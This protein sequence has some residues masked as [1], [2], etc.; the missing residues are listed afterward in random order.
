[1]LGSLMGHLVSARRRLQSDETGTAGAS[2]RLRRPIR[3]VAAAAAAT[4]AAR[5]AVVS[6]RASQPAAVVE[7]PKERRRDAGKANHEPE[8]DRA[9]HDKEMHLLQ[10]RLEGHYTDMKNFIRTRAEPTIFYLPAK[11]TSKTQRCLEETRSAIEQKIRALKVHLRSAVF[12]DEALASEDEGEDDEEEEEEDEEEEEELEEDE[13][14]EESRAV[15]A[16][17]VDHARDRR[18]A[19]GRAPAAAPV[20]AQPSRKRRR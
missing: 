16:D 5:A 10:Q 7:R 19:G 18:V 8:N 4:A 13:E 15:S 11:H 3:T 12:G 6:V 9:T 14:E 20:A 17:E 2:S 1:M